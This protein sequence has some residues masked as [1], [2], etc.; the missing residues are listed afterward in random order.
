ML[1]GYC[2]VTVQNQISH[3]DANEETGTRKSATLTI[4]VASPNQIRRITGFDDMANKLMTLKEGTVITVFGETLYSGE[5]A[6]AGFNVISLH[7]IEQPETE[8]QASAEAETIE[9]DELV[10]A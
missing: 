1:D 6:Q 5:Q 9:E 7:I 8:E 10:T 3:K 2:K 4:A